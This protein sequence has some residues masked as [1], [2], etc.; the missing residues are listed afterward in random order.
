[1]GRL[2][3]P[4]SA[5]SAVSRARGKQPRSPD[6]WR[7]QGLF[8][9]KPSRSR[10]R[11]FHGAASCPASL[12]APAALA[13]LPL[14]PA[15]PHH[16]GSLRAALGTHACAFAFSFASFPLP[17][18]RKRGQYKTAIVER[19]GVVWHLRIEVVPLLRC[20]GT[21]RFSSQIPRDAS[22]DA[23]MGRIFDRTITCPVERQG[24]IGAALRGCN[25]ADHE[26]AKLHWSRP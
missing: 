19:N 9:A 26:Q 12:R 6:L 17:V 25:L 24:C 14:L 1:M 21:G 7:N 3:F 11:A 18:L 22:L 2:H 23:G 15:R 16:L 20:C 4:R 8:P 10:G 5:M 13:A